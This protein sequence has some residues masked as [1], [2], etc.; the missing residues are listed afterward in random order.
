MKTK[1]HMT[2]LVQFFLF[3]VLSLGP[4]TAVFAS[5]PVP[6]AKQKKPVALVGGR[7]YTV[8]GGVIEKGTVVFD[9]GKIVAVG[10]NVPIPENADRV[11]VSG[12]NVYPG[13]IVA[14]SIMGLTEIG[15]VRGTLDYAETG[16]VNP[17]VRAE[18]AVNPESELIPV[19]RS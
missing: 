15:S 19:A 16:S 10:T 8:S 9:G 12:K 7:I 14:S 5:D 1:A 3:T 13:L 11:D 18:V 4:G 2:F 17:N 6:A